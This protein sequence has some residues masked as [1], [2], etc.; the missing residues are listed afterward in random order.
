[1]TQDIFD[2]AELALEPI[3]LQKDLCPQLE[4]WITQDSPEICEE[5]SSQDLIQ[6]DFF[7]QGLDSVGV[8]KIVAGTVLAEAVAPL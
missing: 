8:R 7:S 5:V 6:V 1:L 3:L 4:D 2:V